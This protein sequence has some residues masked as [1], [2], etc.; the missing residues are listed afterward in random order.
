[1]QSLR[2]YD[3][4]IPFISVDAVSVRKDGVLPIVREMT[5]VP[6]RSD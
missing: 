5:G 4:E 2:K 6:P 3:R 1:M